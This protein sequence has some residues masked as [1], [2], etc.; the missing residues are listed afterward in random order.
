V[1]MSFV[2]VGIFMTLPNTSLAWLRSE[3]YWIGQ[4]ANWIEGLY[5]TV[6]TV[7]VLLFALLGLVTGLAF[8]A[9]A[10]R[11]LVFRLAL[12]G[13]A[14]ECIQFWVPGR[15]PLLSDFLMDMLGVLAG[16]WTGTLCVTGWRK[17]N[18]EL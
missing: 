10:L 8:P 9:L 15:T 11:S 2:L 12:F 14:S 7:H 17:M 16:G 18:S 1:L 4:P 3:Y 13:A 5:P 6:D